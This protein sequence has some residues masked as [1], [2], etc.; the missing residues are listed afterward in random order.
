M[1]SRSGAYPTSL[2][3]HAAPTYRRRPLPQ[4]DVRGAVVAA[5][6]HAQR[7]RHWARVAAGAKPRGD[8]EL[9]SV[10]RLHGRKHSAS[11]PD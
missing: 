9:G 4:A 3:G 1:R 5:A 2:N 6:A 7:G 11:R 8:A 10:Y